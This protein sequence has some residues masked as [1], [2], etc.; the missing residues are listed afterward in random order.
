M[1][2]VTQRWFVS[3]IGAIIGALSL[4]LPWMSISASTFG[5][6]ASEGLSPVQFIARVFGPV[7]SSSSSQ[8]TD[9]ATVTWEQS[10]VLGSWLW[11]IG[12]VALGIGC[13]C[14]ILQPFIHS[15]IGGIVMLVGSGMGGAGVASFSASFSTSSDVQLSIG[16]AYGIAVA[17]VASLVALLS[18]FMRDIPMNQPP[19]TQTAPASNRFCPTCG[20][21]YQQEYEHCPR[22]GTELRPVQ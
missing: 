11:L 14:A 17:L 22:D 2:Q 1:V 16:P 13:V 8:P 9:P 4:F 18:F 10:A 6:T 21:W 15:R 20:Q 19:A 3:V 12:T 5:A 7:T